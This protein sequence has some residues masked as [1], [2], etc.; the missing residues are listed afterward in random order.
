MT[1]KS[2]TSVKPPRRNR[3]ISASFV[4]ADRLKEL[5]GNYPKWLR[6]TR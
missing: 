6:G 2:S 3:I 1:T 4:R 5:N